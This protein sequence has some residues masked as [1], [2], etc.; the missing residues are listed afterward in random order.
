MPQSLL[1]PA[2]VEGEYHYT[3]CLNPFFYEGN[4]KV[5]LDVCLLV[6]SQLAFSSSTHLISAVSDAIPDDEDFQWL[7]S[8]RKLQWSI[9]EVKPVE[10]ASELA[11]IRKLVPYHRI[12]VDYE[13]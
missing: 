8:N 9:G 11:A 10:S 6:A 2:L 4:D 5:I 7:T 3:A 1:T 12:F 13:W